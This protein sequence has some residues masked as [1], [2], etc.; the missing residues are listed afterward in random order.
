M[1]LNDLILLGAAANGQCGAL[2]GSC[3]NNL[4]CSS[5]GYCETTSAYCGA[6]CQFAYGTCNPIS[7][8]LPST[9]SPTANPNG[10]C[11]N[12]IGNCAKGF[13]CSSA[14]YCGSTSAYCGTGCQS[15]YGVC[16]FSTSTT[17][18]LFPSKAPTRSPTAKPSSKPTTAPS[19][20]TFN[21]S[22]LQTKSC[23]I[24]IFSV[25]GP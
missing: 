23:C 21:C 2:Y 12:G 19:Y 22:K 15:A 13:C 5:Y 1:V 17:P 8:S 6:G 16:T 20:K 25:K 9:P 10:K 3:L 24:F 11:G 18:T 4:C 14:G 7:P